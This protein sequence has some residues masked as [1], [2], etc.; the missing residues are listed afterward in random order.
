MNCPRCGFTFSPSMNFCPN[1]GLQVKNTTEQYMNR[2]QSSGQRRSQLPQQT[3]NTPQTNNN[4]SNK[5]QF[6]QQ[7]QQRSDNLA[8]D[9]LSS[10]DYIQQYRSSM[11]ELDEISYKSPQS[12]RMGK[13]QEYHLDTSYHDQYSDMPSQQMPSSAQYYPKTTPIEP[14]PNKSINRHDLLAEDYRTAPQGEAYTFKPKPKPQPKPQSKPQPPIQHRE[15]TQRKPQPIPPSSSYN[16]P[17]PQQ[18][19]QYRTPP[20]QP[21]PTYQMEG[22]DE[23]DWI[24]ERQKNKINFQNEFTSQ[25]RMYARNTADS[26]ISRTNHGGVHSTDITDTTTLPPR[27]R[28]RAESNYLASSNYNERDL[29]DDDDD[30]DDYKKSKNIFSK[31]WFLI[32]LLLIV[33]A[34]S[35][36]ALQMSGVV[37]FKETFSGIF[38]E[39][40]D[41][42]DTDTQQVPNVNDQDNGGQ[43][44]NNPD[45]APIETPPST[46]INYDNNIPAK[47]LLDGIKDS[48]ILALGDKMN[49]SKYQLCIENVEQVDGDGVDTPEDGQE[50]LMAEITQENTSSEEGLVNPYYF[51]IVTVKDGKETAFDQINT[52]INTNTALTSGELQPGETAEG[53]I[54]FMVNSDADSYYIVFEPETPNFKVIY[55]IG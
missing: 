45:T 16:R 15:P 25:S 13:I 9:N 49:V 52:P 1:C 7:R 6:R 35:A 54:V 26:P 51:K 41:D 17:K 8:N 47:P 28:R 5:Q 36:I 22:S 23:D 20:Q 42:N 43:V 32:L 19:Q 24:R 31:P 12:N 50:F 53:T 46:D 21:K 40:D 2:P 30:D 44:N 10:P 4:S 34:I 55:K 11:D 39:S 37:D 38:S 14:K 3:N 48:E 27:Y 18:Q 33:L 29:M